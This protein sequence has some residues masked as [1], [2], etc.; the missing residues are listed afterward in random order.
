MPPKKASK[1]GKKKSVAKQAMD[2][3][4][5][6]GPKAAA[7]GA[8]ARTAYNIYEIAKL[9]GMLNAEKKTFTISNQNVAIG[10][11]I[12]NNNGFYSF[13]CTPIPAQG[14]TSITRNGNSIKLHSSFIRMQFSQQSGTVNPIKVRIRMD[15]VKGT[16]QSAGTWPSTILEPNPFITGGGSIYDYNSQTNADYFGILKTIFTRQIVVRQDTVTSGTTITDVMIPLK[17]FR[18]KGHHVRFAQDGAQ[19]ISDGQL[20]L[21]VTCDNGNA[22]TS[23]ACTLSGPPLGGSAANTGLQMSYNIIHYFYDN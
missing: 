7:V 22:S 11:V 17:Y 13:D 15:L 4:V 18:G 2:A 12:V 5:K 20:I 9:V 3:V 1:K 8:A 10:Q 23:T 21:F 6:Y 14:T 19:T 16:P